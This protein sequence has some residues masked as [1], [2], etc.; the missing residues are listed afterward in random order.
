[1]VPVQAYAAGGPSAPVVV[2]VSACGMPVRPAEAWIRRLAAGHR[3]LTW[4]SRGLLGDVP[5]D[6]DGASGVAAQAGDPLAVMDHVTVSSAH[7][8][9]LCGGAVISLVAAAARPD[10]IASM[11]PWHGDFELGDDALKTDH[12]RNLQGLT[13]LATG[14]GSVRPGSRR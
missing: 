7:V 4:E 9:G 2:I 1:M 13:S 6:F 8:A 5:A 14:R 11:S 12:Q 10:R 3:V